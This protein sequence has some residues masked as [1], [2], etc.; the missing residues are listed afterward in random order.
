[1]NV[2]QGEVWDP[3]QLIVWIASRN[4][5]LAGRCNANY[6]VEDVER[7][8][9]LSRGEHPPN[10]ISAEE[11]L[12]EVRRH[13]RSLIP[14]KGNWPE[15]EP[16]SKEPNFLEYCNIHEFKRFPLLFSP[17]DVMRLWPS[18]REVRAFSL[19]LAR[20][21][22]KPARSRATWAKQL[23]NGELLPLG[24]IL[25]A[26]V[27][28]GRSGP[29]D[30]VEEQ[31][32]RLNSCIGILKAA[33]RSRIRIYGTPCRR[34][35]KTPREL[36]EADSRIEIEAPVAAT[37]SPVLDGE[38][39]WLGP[40]EYALNFERDGHAPESVRFCRV[41]VD[42]KSLLNWLSEPSDA[43]L[44]EN[45][46]AEMIRAA[47]RD[48]PGLGIDKIVPQIQKLDRY[49]TRDAIRMVAKNSDRVGR[50]GRPKKSAKIIPPEY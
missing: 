42:R 7:A 40:L 36:E 3:L 43:E 6:F 39:D 15:K 1:M 45:Q 8:V 5:S 2:V 48:T 37:L 12:S 13:Y 30:L 17:A 4:I 28:R 21:W 9:I 25:D 19:A 16:N 38:S 49:W 29:N 10:P 14:L 23:S 32:A 31:A 46:V 26:V 11:A 44:S 22:R 34:S 50:R 41:V 24:Q 18:H 20:Q 27:S 33:A 47:Q 35:I